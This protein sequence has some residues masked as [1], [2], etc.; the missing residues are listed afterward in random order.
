MI[1]LDLS[2]LDR[3][4]IKVVRSQ[5][6]CGEAAGNF[7]PVLRYVGRVGYLQQVCGKPG[8]WSSFVYLD[9]GCSSGATAGCSQACMGILPV[10]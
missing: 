3:A 6:D 8:G 5:L 4:S 10:L 7:L 9:S 1:W 2:G